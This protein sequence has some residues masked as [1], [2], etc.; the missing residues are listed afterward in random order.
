MASE[1]SPPPL[2][3]LLGGKSERMG[4][5]KGLLAFKETFWLN[6]QLNAIKQAGLKEV[7]VV[8]GYHAQRYLEVFQAFLQ[9]D[10]TLLYQDLSITTLINKSPEH[11]PFSTIQTG[12]SYFLN[13]KEA[14][15][16]M[17][18]SSAISS[19]F[20]SFLAI[21]VPCPAPEVFEALFATI[22]KKQADMVYPIREGLDGHPVFLSHRFAKQI[23]SVLPEKM[24][25]KR[26]RQTLLPTKCLALEQKSPLIGLNLNTPEA[27]KY[28][29][30]HFK[31]P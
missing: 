19:Y 3:L 30:E 25:M 31:N 27:W 14:L 22:L 13:K 5:P 7:C 18:S 20:Y 23:V 16:K 6:H 2:V 11:G 17:D 28:F 9:Q 1:F 26:L 12:L 10:K 24:S 21:D 29:L 4:T 8:L 15:E